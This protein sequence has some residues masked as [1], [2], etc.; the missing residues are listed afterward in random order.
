[1]STDVTVGSTVTLV[2]TFSPQGGGGAVILSSLIDPLADRG[3]NVRWVWFGEEVPGHEGR[4]G[5]SLTGG[6]VLS[7]VVRATVMW[8]T[9][10]KSRAI[11]ATVDNLLALVSGPF[12]VVGHYEGILLARELAVRGEGIHLTIHD[13]PTHGLAQRSRRYRHLQRAISTRTLDAMC[14]A[15]SVD[16]VSEGMRRHYID[17]FGIDS[18]VTH[19]WLPEDWELPTPQKAYDPLSMPLRIGHVGSI[20]AIDDIRALARAVQQL[21]AGGTPAQLVMIAPSGPVARFLAKYFGELVE[22]HR[23]IPEPEVLAVLRTC[24]MAYAAYPFAKQ[25]RTFR[26]TSLPTKITTYLQA[27]LPI[28]ARTPADS[29]L[30]D[31]VQRTG[32]GTLVQGTSI[33]S[34]RSAIRS[35]MTTS[36]PA[37]R[38][39]EARDHFFG[40]ANLDRLTSALSGTV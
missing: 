23:P 12:W 28:L 22:I 6:P 27:P 2:T 13:D 16:V 37:C 19:R 17:R 8:I 9:P 15:Q 11:S 34:L 7:D 26:R 40:N 35:L 32:T 25:Y 24:T 29:T 39:R 4:I 21:I 20:Y 18:I 33:E 10:A 5:P 3:V 31:F 36:I 30:V 38:Y 1:M 14:T